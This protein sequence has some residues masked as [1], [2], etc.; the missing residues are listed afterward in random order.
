MVAGRLVEN[1]D[2]S[3]DVEQQGLAL[4]NSNIVDEESDLFAA[5]MA[6]LT[7]DPELPQVNINRDAKLSGPSA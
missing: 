5:A 2:Q 7:S 6:E 4:G 1:I 3:L